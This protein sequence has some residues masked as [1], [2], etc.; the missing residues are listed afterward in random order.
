[1]PNWCM[2]QLEIAGDASEGKRFVETN[3]ELPAEYL[4][5]PWE[6]EPRKRPTLPYFC[7]LVPTPKE[8][9]EM[10]QEETRFLAAAHNK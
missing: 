1:M 5:P 9:I 8:V 4:P 3:R 7:A 10:R 6:K 2:N